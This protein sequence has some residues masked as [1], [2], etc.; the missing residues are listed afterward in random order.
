MTKAV[1]IDL[2][3][4]QTYCKCFYGITQTQLR[5]QPHWDMQ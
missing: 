1:V 5:I 4:Y 3:K 2:A